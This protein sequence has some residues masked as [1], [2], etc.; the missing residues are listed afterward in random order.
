MRW[1]RA[2]LA[3]CAVAAVAAGCGSSSNSSSSSSAGASSSSASASA[4]KAPIT[5]LSIGDTTGPTKIIG[6]T[7]LAGL[8]AGA[9]YYNAHGGIDGHKVIIHHF[10]DNG[11]STTAVSVLIQQLQGGTPPTMIDAG[12]EGGDAAALIPVIAK[13]NVFAL[14]LNDGTHQCLTN[15]QTTCPNE[16]TLADHSLEDE[17]PVAAFFKAHGIKKVGI[18][19]D[20]STSRRPSRP[21]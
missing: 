3:A 17:L 2:G 21:R 7:H 19:Q 12:S 11:D 4:S 10:S 13:H 15:S 8:E 18:L 20:R 9:A 6:Q 16:F 14:A 1:S 5:I